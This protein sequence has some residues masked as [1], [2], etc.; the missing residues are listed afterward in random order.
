MYVADILLLVELAWHWLAPVTLLLLIPFD[1][2]IQVTF[3]LC[4]HS[5]QTVFLERQGLPAISECSTQ[6]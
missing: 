2:R 3:L 5:V 4:V 1:A 6:S